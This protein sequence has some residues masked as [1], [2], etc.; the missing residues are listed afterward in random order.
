MYLGKWLLISAHTSNYEAT[1]I[2]AS[3]QSTRR[4]GQH[5]YEAFQLRFKSDQCPTNGVNWQGRVTRLNTKANL[6]KNRNPINFK[7]TSLRWQ[8]KGKHPEWT[9]SHLAWQHSPG[10]RQQRQDVPGSKSLF[11]VPQCVTVRLVKMWSYIPGEKIM[12]SGGHEKT[13]HLNAYP[14]YKRPGLYVDIPIRGRN[15][16]SDN[17]VT[18]WTDKQ[19]PRAPE[20]YKLS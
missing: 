13:K 12:S 7:S 19:R 10:R 18:S 9:A 4:L 2:S 16:E 6:R 11:W 15:C 1:G 20:C 8:S 17:T 14:N 5:F 3:W